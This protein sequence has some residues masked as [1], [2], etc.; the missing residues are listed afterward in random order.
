MRSRAAAAQEGP[1]PWTRAPGEL[2]GDPIE[3]VPIRPPE[4]GEPAMT[5]HDV[6][7][8]LARAHRLREEVEVLADDLGRLLDRLQ[9]GVEMARGQQAPACLR[10]CR[11]GKPGRA[12][13]AKALVQVGQAAEERAVEVVASREV[14]DQVAGAV[15]D[16]VHRE[17]MHRRAL[18]HRPSPRDADAVAVPGAADFQ[19]GWGWHGVV[20]PEHVAG[21]LT[22]EPTLIIRHPG[23]PASMGRRMPYRKPR[24]PA[25]GGRGSAA[26]GR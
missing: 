26:T 19:G 10:G 22:D 14:D 1:A 21:R 17:L 25:P 13:P 16:G 20:L 7:A 23:P 5:L 9:Q 6:V 2:F 8:E 15:F 3:G 24:R 4:L 12:R 18:A 11:D